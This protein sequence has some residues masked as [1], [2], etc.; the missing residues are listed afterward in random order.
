M[1]S[2]REGLLDFLF[3]LRSGVGG[4]A[5]KG[6]PPGARSTIGVESG[7]SLSTEVSGVGLGV[8]VTSVLLFFSPVPSSSSS[9]RR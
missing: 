7:V 3:D 9:S 8:E 6:S 2:Y 4:L 5:T 1:S